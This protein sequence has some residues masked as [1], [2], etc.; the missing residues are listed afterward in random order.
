MSTTETQKIRELAWGEL[1]AEAKSE[2]C[3]DLH[4]VLS[5]WIRD[6]RLEVSAKSLWLRVEPALALYISLD[7]DSE[8]PFH[9]EYLLDAIESDIL[10]SMVT[11]A[12]DVKSTDLQA[13]IID[14]AWMRR[15][16]EHSLVKD[17]V[18]AYLQSASNRLEPLHWLHAAGRFKRAIEVARTIGATQRPFIEAVEAI[19]KAIE[20]IAGEDP[21]YLSHRLMSLLLRFR[22]G[23]AKHY[24]NL[25]VKI[26]HQAQ[27]NYQTNGV[28]DGGECQREREYLGLAVGWCRISKQDDEVRTLRL[29]I[30][31]AFVRQADGVIAASWPSA[32]S[33]AAHFVEGAIKELRQVGGE[34]THVDELR[35]KH[36]SL[37]RD[38]VAEMRGFEFSLNVSKEVRAARDLVSGKAPISALV[39][40]AWMHNPPSVAELAEEVAVNARKTPFKSL[41]PQSFVGPRGTILAE[42]AGVL[43]QHD[44]NGLAIETMRVA[45]SRQVS[46]A[47]IFFHAS[48]EQIRSEHGLDTP[49]FLGLAQASSFVP[50]G[51]ERSYARGLAAGLRG[52]YE[53]AATIL[54]SQ[55]E[56]ALRE[57]FYTYGAVTSTL[58]SSRVQNEHNLNQLLESDRAEEVLG[59]TLT[60]DLRVL[61]T[62]KAGANLR[63]D[64]AHGLI[65]D[66]ANIGSKIYLW[67]ICLRFALVPLASDEREPIADEETPSES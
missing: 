63:N 49:W 60:F 34:R 42:H 31:K 39:A 2:S 16:C 57:L 36:Q 27:Q 22:V 37:Q 61:L 15:E 64:L 50:T 28:G 17:C 40:F 8:R 59:K 7:S 25:A 19:E 48:A 62:E 13:R 33:V 9:P 41:V 26:A 1:V 29:G 52:D 43:D 18:D 21:L 30:A 67:W 14:I 54:C 4:R 45:A 20:S 6:E 58:P 51:R 65:D 55:F 38:A 56:H 32:K 44:G 3:E 23:D 53:L 5:G 47:T 46:V 11:I 12:G 35:R 24:A 66:N 10:V